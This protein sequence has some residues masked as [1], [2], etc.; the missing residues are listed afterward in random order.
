MIVQ[1][2]NTYECRE[3]CVQMSFSDDY[4]IFKSVNLAGIILIFF[5]TSCA[6][7]CDL[8][9]SCFRGHQEKM[10]CITQLYKPI[11]NPFP[12]YLLH[13]IIFKVL[14]SICPDPVVFMSNA[15]S[16]L[17]VILGK[18]CRICEGEALSISWRWLFIQ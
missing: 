12:L 10:C 14:V 4:L 13:F 16:Y 11:L 6:H 9:I 1:F 3:L 15:K 8:N 18:S 5:K 7:C 17:L 2:Q